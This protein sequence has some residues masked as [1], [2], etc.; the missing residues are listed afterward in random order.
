MSWLCNSFKI[1]YIELCDYNQ[2]TGK[3]WTGDLLEVRSNCREII[4]KE[5]RQSCGKRLATVVTS[6]N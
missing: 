2:N 6:L 3:L 5:N 1:I 4:K